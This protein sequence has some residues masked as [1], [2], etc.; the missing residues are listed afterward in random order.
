MLRVEVG[1][2]QLLRG[3]GSIL[4]A[5]AHYETQVLHI[6]HCRI[7]LSHRLVMQAVKLLKLLS[8][9]VRTRHQRR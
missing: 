1:G 6:R 2:E 5:Q 3:G 9:G 8:H 4:Q 7:L